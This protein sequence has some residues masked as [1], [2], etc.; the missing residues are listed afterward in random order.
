VPGTERPANPEAVPGFDQAPGMTPHSRPRQVRGI[1]AAVRAYPRALAALAV[2]GVFFV[3]FRPWQ[4]GL[5][6]DWGLALAWQNE[7]FAGFGARIP[8]MLGRPLHLLPQYVGMWMSNGGFV[9]PYG[10][11]G[12]IAVGQLIAALW[13]VAPLTTNRLLRWTFALAIALHPWWTAGDILRFMPAQAAVLGVVVWLGAAVRFLRSGRAV[14]IP[15]MVLPPIIGLLNYQAPAAALVIGS[16]AV[17]LTTSATWRRRVTVVLLAIAASG[18]VMV[19]SVVIAPRLSP[20]SY[21][22]QL[23]SQHVDVVGSMR[24]ILRTV[25]LH[26]PATALAALIVALVVIAL[27]FNQHLPT[28]ISWLLLLA[29]ASAPLAALVY[30]S[31][32]LHLNDPERVALPIGVTLWIV[33]CAALPALGTDRITRVLATVFLLAGTLVGALSGYHTWTSY[34]H[35]QQELLHAVQAVREDLPA[36]AQLVVADESGRFG[37][38]YLLLPPHLNIA[39]DEEFG[40]GAD[41]ILCTPD[42][43]TRRQPTAA[44][45]PIGTTPDC[46]TLLTGAVVTSLG[47]STTPDGTFE[48]YELPPAG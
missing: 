23:I 13:A 47:A 25:A 39:L 8:M 33:A 46:S 40:Q 12:V 15:L 30:A 48:F 43:V 41:A 28:G 14:W 36:D 29:T 3:H 4:A 1:A 26:A 9:G 7:G 44:V 10:I 22:S 20:S 42:G 24:L 31:E 37:D 18:T 6:E 19:W 45:Y 16:V 32:P 11:L 35:S 38:V 27:G 5:L 34:A 2:L 17:A 21:E